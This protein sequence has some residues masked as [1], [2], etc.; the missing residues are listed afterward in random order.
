MTDEIPPELA[1]IFDFFDRLPRKGPGSKASTLRALEFLKPLPPEPQVV[2]FGCGGGAS[3]LPL[4]EAGCRVSAVDIHQPFLDE[5][6]TAARAVG[7]SDRITTHVADMGEPPFPNESFDL[8][9]AEAAIYNIGFDEGLK[10]WRP[11]LR[12][13]GKIAV[14]EVTWLSDDSPQEIVDFWHREYPAIT[15]IAEN[16][17]HLRNAGFELIDSFPLPMQDWAD[18]Y[19]PE[20]IE[21]DRFRAEHADDPTAQAVMDALQEEID[22]W[23]RHGEHYG[24]VFYLGEKS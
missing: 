10:R 18:Y 19:E 16:E 22:V 7:L 1:I 11:L 12:P 13:G 6:M 24:Y 9:W 3:T 4:A 14:S 23:R 15:T 2:D 5:V 17:E 8:I 21:L 20:Q